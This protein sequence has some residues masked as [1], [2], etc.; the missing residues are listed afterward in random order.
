MEI[1]DAADAP[2]AFT[3]KKRRATEDGVDTPKKARS[4]KKDM[5]KEEPETEEGADSL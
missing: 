5:I 2:P 3:P 1:E 4:G